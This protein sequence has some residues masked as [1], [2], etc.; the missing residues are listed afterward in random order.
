MDSDEEEVQCVHARMLKC[1]EMVYKKRRISE[2]G[3]WVEGDFV[4]GNMENNAIECFRRPTIRMPANKGLKRLEKRKKNAPQE[5][6]SRL[7]K[8]MR[9]YLKEVTKE[10]ILDD[11]EDLTDFLGDL[12]VI[13][14]RGSSENG[15]KIEGM[16]E[17]ETKMGGLKMKEDRVDKGPKMVWLVKGEDVWKSIAEKMIKEEL[18]GFHDDDKKHRIVNTR[19]VESRRRMGKRERREM[20]GWLNMEKFMGEDQEKKQ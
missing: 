3:R 9:Y 8:G 19:I 4:R 10:G 16:G 11:I 12:S 17:L 5:R 20:G 1:D 13:K 15:S 18:G 6:L 2:K 14:M 7:S